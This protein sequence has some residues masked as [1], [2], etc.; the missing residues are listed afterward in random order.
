MPSLFELRQDPLIQDRVQQRL[1][2]LNQLVNTGDQKIKSQRGG[3][4]VFVEHRVKWPHKFVLSGF[5]KE[6]VSYDQLSVVQWVAGFCCTRKEENNSKM[7]EHMLDYFVSLLDA[8]DF[9]WGAAKASHTVLLCRME[10]GEIGDY[11]CTD[12]IDRIRRA[13]AQRHASPNKL[14]VDKKS[15][16]RATQDTGL[17]AKN[18]K[19]RVSFTDTYVHIALALWV[20][21]LGIMK[22]T[23]VIHQKILKMN[24]FGCTFCPK[25]H[26]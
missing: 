12:Q 15:S 16:Q 10:Q 24:K 26:P 23:V 9:S 17:S 5:T 18:M 13:N 20:K 7:R 11:S 6:R 21:N 14:N 1:Q 19:Q 22:L 2:E 4:D 8:Q 3:V 25:A